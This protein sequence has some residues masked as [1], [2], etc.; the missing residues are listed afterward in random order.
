MKGIEN[1]W[2]VFLDA[3]FFLN[4]MQEM[5]LYETWKSML[6]NGAD[7][8]HPGMSIKAV[9]QNAKCLLCIC[10]EFCDAHSPFVWKDSH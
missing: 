2:D 3:R 1:V 7:W 10:M 9:L 6:D 4:H 8:L 5:E